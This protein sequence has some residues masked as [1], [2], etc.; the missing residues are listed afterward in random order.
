[1]SKGMGVGWSQVR[2]G[3]MRNEDTTPIIK[4]WI[5][6]KKPQKGIEKH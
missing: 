6:E 2:V 1:M 5:E 3:R 4:G